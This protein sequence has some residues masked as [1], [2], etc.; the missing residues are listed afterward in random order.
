MAANGAEVRA[1]RVPQNLNAVVILIADD[2]VALVV[3]S[4]ASRIMELPVA[5]A[6][7]AKHAQAASPRGRHTAR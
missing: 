6:L 7:A 2:K 3:E 5:C 4:A 1:V